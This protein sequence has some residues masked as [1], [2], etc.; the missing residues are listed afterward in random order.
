MACRLQG[1]TGRDDTSGLES[2]GTAAPKRLFHDGRKDQPKPLHTEATLL[3]AME[4]AG[5]EY[6]GR[7]TASALKDC[8]IGTPATRASVIETLFA[9]EYVTRQK[10]CLVPTEKGLAL[11][12]IVRPCA[13]PT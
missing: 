12:S 2:R 7:G 10:K 5:R 6:R 9:R 11:Y 1:R 3:S 13:L 4:T 8:G